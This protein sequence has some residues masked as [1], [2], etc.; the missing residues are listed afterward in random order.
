MTSL[1]DA[2]IKH[3]A[4]YVVGFVAGLLDGMAPGTWT[5]INLYHDD[6]GLYDVAVVEGPLDRNGNLWN[7]P[8]GLELPNK[9]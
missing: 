1:N 9:N 2:S 8:E 7:T 3:T 5:S 6:N 4:T